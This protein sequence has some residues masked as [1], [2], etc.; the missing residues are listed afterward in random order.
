MKLQPRKSDEPEINLTPLIDVVFLLLIFFMVTTTFV[1]DSNL[2]ITLPE[3]STDPARAQVEVVE[4][5]IDK[6]GNV[7]LD[8]RTLVNNQ[9]D[10]IRRALLKLVQERPNMPPLVIRADAQT[11]HQNVI[12]AL[13]A[14]GDVGIAKVGM[15]TVPSND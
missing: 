9:Y 6:E 7:S 12:T 8:G 1:R 13:D 4:L 5:L 11:P 14:A 15:A 3:A 2:E 10:T